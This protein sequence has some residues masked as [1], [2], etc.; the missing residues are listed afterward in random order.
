MIII[1]PLLKSSM[2]CFIVS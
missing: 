2:I 1:Y